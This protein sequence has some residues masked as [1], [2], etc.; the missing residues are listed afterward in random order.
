ME[1]QKI[2]LGFP[3]LHEHNPE[4]DWRKG[5]VTWKA[6]KWDF[7]KWANNKK[8][9]KVTIKEELNEDEEKNQTKNP[10]KGNINT[11]FAKLL[12]ETNINKINVATKLAIEENKKKEEK[13]DEELIPKEYHEY[14]DVLVKK[15][16]HDFLSHNPRIIKLK[17]RKDL[18]QN[19]LK[20]TI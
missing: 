15:R 11:I 2:V 10:I 14:L 16:L 5:K 17:Q 13:T 1:K 12:E 7:Q 8:I 20:T 4:I 6:Q 9:S 18:R 19:H 3:W